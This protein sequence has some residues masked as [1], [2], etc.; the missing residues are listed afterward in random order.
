MK[1]FPAC[2]RLLPAL[3]ALSMILAACAPQAT[4][5]PSPEAEKPAETQVAEEPEEQPAVEPTAE[6]PAAEKPPAEIP[7]LDFYYVAFAAKPEDLAEVEKAVNAILE[8]KIGA[9]LKL[10]PLTF[11]DMPTKAPLILTSGEPCDLMTFS[12]FNPYNNGVASGGLIPLDDLLPQYA[13]KTWAHFPKEIWDAMRVKGKIYGAINDTGGWVG[14]G[15][16]WARQDLLDKYQFDWASTETIEDWEPYFDQ[17]LEGENGEVIPLVST[18]SYW[19]RLWFPHYYGYDPVDQGIGAPGSRGILGVKV[20][21]ETRT[22]VAVPFTEEYRLAVE[23]ARRWYEKGYFLKTPPTDSEMIAM[24]SQLKFAVFHFPGVGYFSTKKMAENEWQNINIIAHP[25]QDKPIITTGAIQGSAYGVCAT[26][27]HPDLAVKYIEEVNNNPELLNLLNF[28]IEGKHWVWVDEENKVI[29]NPPGV[30]AA[31]VGYN[32]NSYWQF[33]DRH[34]LYFFGPDDIGVFEKIDAAMKDA[35]F[36]PVM[37]FTP[38]RSPIEN[39]IAQIASAA[40]Q[41]CDPVEKGLVEVESGLVDCQNALKEAGIDVVLAE[42]Q[43]QIDEWAA[44]NKP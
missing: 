40:K 28:G 2:F 14:Y 42:L 35:I 4:P 43:R 27:K 22:I 23:T 36:S 24:R 31:N 39:E 33:G 44:A 21:D 17:V 26:S 7:T 15:G 1:T 29:G 30:D 37:G 25:L 32:P 38:D 18:D 19:G 12:Q 8:P 41:Y 13:P 34:N 5:T 6:E 9:R 11:G 10:H 3:V 20:D 16:M